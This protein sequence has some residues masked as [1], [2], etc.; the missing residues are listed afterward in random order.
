PPPDAC[1]GPTEASVMRPLNRRE[2][3]NTIRDL[4]GIDTN[5]TD[6][7][8]N[9]PLVGFDN[10]TQSLTPSDVLT[11]QHLAAAE[12]LSSQANLGALAPGATADAACA[13]DFIA[14]FGR[15]AFRRPIEA[16]ESADLLG[17]Y[18]RALAAGRTHDQAIRLV[19]E[20]FLMTPQFLHRVETSVS[21]A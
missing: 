8:P 4:L 13:T 11:E 1:T 7:F 19:I 10:Q 9:D 5:V 14:R 15:R 3:R 12:T 16:T 18:T 17:V 21:A 2:Y 6:A 20:A